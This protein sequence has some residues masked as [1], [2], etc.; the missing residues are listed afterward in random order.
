MLILDNKEKWNM[1]WKMVKKG[2]VWKR[3]IQFDVED[4]VCFTVIAG[5]AVVMFLRAI[6]RGM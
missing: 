1:K 2:N 3:R 5:V 4:W 6:I